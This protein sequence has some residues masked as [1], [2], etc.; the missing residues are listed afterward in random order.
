LAEGGVEP[1]AR[2]Y[3]CEN[4]GK[5]AVYGIAEAIIC[6]AVHIEIISERDNNDK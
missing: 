5:K 6:G 2:G 1:D 3:E 4:C